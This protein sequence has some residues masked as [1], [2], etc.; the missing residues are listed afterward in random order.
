MV[1][2]A[3]G[4]PSTPSQLFSSVNLVLHF[5]PD[6]GG[7]SSAVERSGKLVSGSRNGDGNWWGLLRGA[8]WRQSMDEVATREMECLN[9]E[10]S[11]ALRCSDM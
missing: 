11:A 3:S 10:A 7:R 5:I 1:V 6:L 2:G 8:P 4:G 9:N